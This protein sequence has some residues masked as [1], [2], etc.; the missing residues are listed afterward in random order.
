MRLTQWSKLRTLALLFV[1]ANRRLGRSQRSIAWSIAGVLAAGLPAQAAGSRPLAPQVPLSVPSNPQAS[2]VE[3]TV[4]APVSQPSPA[5][6]TKTSGQKDIPTKIEP[7]AQEVV[8]VAVGLGP[9]APG[10]K[11]ERSLVDRLEQG[12]MASTR[13]KAS[14]RR[15]RAGSGTARQICRGRRDDLVILVDYLPERPQPTLVTHDCKLDRAL[16]V[17]SG[18][19]AGQ[20]GFVGALWDEHRQLMRDGVKERRAR[21]KMNPKVRTGLL[22]GGAIVVLGTAIGVLI[23][24][25]LRKDT[26]VLTVGP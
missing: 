3:T 15:L 2:A 10:S 7:V 17:R 26:V 4:E 5:P 24:N 18:D 12:A 14:V 19:A 23:A 1:Q 21:L 8:T 6:V 16:G 22:A 20:S 9:Q 11:A 13:P 25:G